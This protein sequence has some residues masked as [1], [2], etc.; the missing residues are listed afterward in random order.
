MVR[1]NYDKR[2]VKDVGLIGSDELARRISNMSRLQDQALASFIYLTAAR[3]SEVLGNKDIDP[4]KAWQ[5]EQEEEAGQVIL[6]V[7]NLPML[8]R[9]ELY[10]RNVPITIKGNQPF[11]N[12]I[13]EWMKSENLEGDDKV[14]PIS[15][16]QT[17]RIFTD[18]LELFPHCLRYLRL[19]HL[20]YRYSFNTAEL[21]EFVGWGSANSSAGYVNLDWRHIARKMVKIDGGSENVHKQTVKLS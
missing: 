7:Q 20:M 19:N 17:Y 14:F 12:Y 2:K 21:Q 16:V 10:H 13:L 3:I 15:R 18:E 9:R 6:V 4:L 5:V 8:K 11:S 1:T